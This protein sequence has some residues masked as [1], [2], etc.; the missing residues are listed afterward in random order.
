MAN[1]SAAEFRLGGALLVSG[2]ALQ[3]VVAFAANLVLV[4][5]L[6]PEEFGRFALILAGASI[7]YSLFSFQTNVLI[8]RAQERDFDNYAK[9]RYFSVLTA[10]TVIAWL[11]LSGWL[12]A[13]GTADSLSISLVTALGL[14]HWIDHNKAYFERGMPYRK[15]ALVET[16]ISLAAHGLAVALVFVGVGWTVL[17]I[18]EIFIA[19]AGVVLFGAVGAL[20]LR[21]LRLLSFGEVRSL[22]REARGIWLDFVLE[23]SFQRLTILFAGTLGGDRIAGLF[24]QAQR[25]A[26]VPHQFLAPLVSRMAANWF[27]RIEDAERR[28]RG[29]NILLGVTSIPLLV[30]AVATYLFADPIVPWLF[31]SSWQRP[32]DLFAAMAGVVAF[33]SLFEIL[34]AYAVI[35]HRLGRLIVARVA[36]YIGLMAFATA[37]FTGAMAADVALS[38][39]LSAAYLAAFVILLVLLRHRAP[40]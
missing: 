11:I 39:G 1:I 13:A 12:V 7:G 29:R 32:A 38:I 21:R 9:D 35:T 5:Y 3:A 16:A 40:S 4:R 8:I 20:T 34:R 2:Q 14:R 23:G 10:E 15:L 6:A 36:Q 31:G 27:G 26:L 37:A 19:F 25:L 24:F 18:R 30:A 17:F 22:V 28:L 33:L